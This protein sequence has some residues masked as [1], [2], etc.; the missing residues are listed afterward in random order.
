MASSASIC[1]PS[2]ARAAD[3]VT[4]GCNGFRSDLYN[5][6]GT[7]CE[8]RDSTERHEGAHSGFYPNRVASPRAPG[9]SGFTP[10]ARLDHDCVFRGVRFNDQPDA[11]A[12][13]LG[14][15]SGH[16]YFVLGDLVLRPAAA[17]GPIGT[18]STNDYSRDWVPDD[19][20][21]SDGAVRLAHVALCEG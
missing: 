21:G 3:V 4:T 1:A 19:T 17:R 18:Y 5:R 11:P 6:A 14:R 13:R 9:S 8:S 15:A 2:S 16:R 12:E 10:L 7:L 20:R